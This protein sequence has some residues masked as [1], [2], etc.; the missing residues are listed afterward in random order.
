MPLEE[1]DKNEAYIEAPSQV[2]ILLLSNGDSYRTSA[3]V[4]ENYPVI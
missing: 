1:E 4:T 3:R 2:L